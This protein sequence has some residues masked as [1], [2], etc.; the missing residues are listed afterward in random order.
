L[1]VSDV[2]DRLRSDHR[3]IC[4]KLPGTSFDLGNRADLRQL[5]VDGRAIA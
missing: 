2:G 5:V 1:A 4:V 3:V